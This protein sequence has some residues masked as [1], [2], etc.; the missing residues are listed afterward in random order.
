[1]LS[2]TPPVPGLPLRRLQSSSS[3]GD[4]SLFPF[5]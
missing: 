1:M 3:F 5:A 4:A 2:N